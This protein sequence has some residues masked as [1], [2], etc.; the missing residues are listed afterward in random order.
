MPSGLLQDRGQLSSGS[1][2]RL[3]LPQPFSFYGA[4][5]STVDVYEDGYVRMNPC[6][7]NPAFCSL[8]RQYANILDKDLVWAYVNP[9]SECGAGPNAGA[10][11]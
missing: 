6:L 11:R 8:F 5:T 10:D 4:Q 9:G 7:G 3:T 2:T 1:P